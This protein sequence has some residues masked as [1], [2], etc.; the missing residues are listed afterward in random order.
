MGV[1][2]QLATRSLFAFSD[3][4][5]TLGAKST[6]LKAVKD[7]IVRSSWLGKCCPRTCHV[8][9]QILFS[10]SYRY[11]SGL[12]RTLT[13]YVSV[14]LYN[15]ACMCH[16]WEKNLEP[17]WKMGFADNLSEIWIVT[18]DVSL[19]SLLEVRSL[20]KNSKGSVIVRANILH[21]VE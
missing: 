19:K 3:V 1:R 8:K 11:S 17:K 9:Q 7:L 13:G 2:F 14:C 5:I 6:S 15:A 20:M 21:P 12:V 10:N 4:T 16:D 18:C